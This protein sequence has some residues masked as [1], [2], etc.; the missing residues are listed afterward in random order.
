M[1]NPSASDSVASS[2]A[3]VGADLF[4]TTSHGVFRS[5]NNGSNWSA[6]NAGLTNYYVHTF[7]VSGSNLFA[8]TG[9]GIFL[10]TNSGTTWAEATS[11][12]ITLGA[13]TL[14]A[15]GTHLYAGMD[16]GHMVSSTDDGTSWQRDN[17]FSGAPIDI[18]EIGTTLIATAAGS[19]SGLYFST[20]QGASWTKPADSGLTKS[21]GST[22]GVFAVIGSNFFVATG[23]GIFRSTDSGANWTPVN[24]GLSD[25]HDF[26]DS[27]EVQTLASSGANLFAATEFSGIYRS[28]DLGEHWIQVN[29]GIGEFSHVGCLAAIGTTILAAIVDTNSRSSVMRSVNNGLSWEAIHTGLPTTVAFNRFIVRGTNI[30]AITFDG[31]LFISTDVGASWSP[32][33]SGLMGNQVRSLAIKGTNV[34]AGIALNGVWRRPLSEMISSGVSVSEQPA[35]FKLDQNYPNPFNPSTVISFVLTARGNVTLEVFDMLGRRVQ[36]LVDQA[37]DAGSHSVKFEAVHLASGIYTAC[38]TTSGTHREMKMILSK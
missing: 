30:F 5:T 28:T 8:G 35:T 10:T 11:N 26:G 37:M 23:L 17:S 22:N 6:V 21:T 20:D 1:I 14:A 18:I 31:S 25:P 16:D 32:I 3:V 12:I 13:N 2:F 27:T 29:V 38:L 7:A 19:G 15:A 4:A 9:S 33:D 34:F 24:S 36:T